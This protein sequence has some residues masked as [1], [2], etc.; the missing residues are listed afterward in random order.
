MQVRIDKRTTENLLY[1]IHVGADLAPDEIVTSILSITVDENPVI[2]LD[3]LFPE[4]LTPSLTFDAV[5]DWSINTEPKTYKDGV[6]AKANSIMQGHI[7]GGVQPGKA[8]FIYT[9]RILY[10]TNINFSP[11]Y[12]REASF[13]IKVLDI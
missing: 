11:S 3:P 5:G 1:D 9:M 2:A 10:F 13:Q 7:G 8:A 12:P 4:V 6:V